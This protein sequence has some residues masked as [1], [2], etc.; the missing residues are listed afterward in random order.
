MLHRQGAGCYGHNSADD[1]AF[2][3]AF[4]A[5]RTPDRT[6]RVQWTREDEFSAA[7]MGSAM[8]V[9]LRAVLD[10][11]SRPADW[12]IDIWSPVH[13]QRPGMNGRANLLGA[14]ALPD[15]PPPAAE[16]NDV[17]DDAGGGATRNGQALYD[18]P[19][20][21][22]V[23]HLLPD[24]PVRTSS[25]R[26]LGAFANVFA[27]ESFMD[28]LAEIAGEDPVAY[29]LS[30]MSDP[31][32]RQVIETAA[33]MGDWFGTPARDGRARGFGFARYKNR[34][35]YAAVV[36][37]VEV[38][39]QVR[40]NRVWA[41]VDAGLVINPD[42]AAQPDRGRHHPGGELDPQGRCSLRRRA[43]RLRQ[44]GELPDLALHRGSGDR[45]PLHRRTRIS[46]RW[47]WAKRRSAPPRRRS[48]TRWRGRS[49]DAFA[50]CH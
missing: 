31:R 47:G 20:H 11:H 3:A 23:H 15:A 4:V 26:G 1:A 36:A 5:M 12:T 17:A 29:R 48:A 25:L 41:A 32:A 18:L 27:I 8:V 16:I 21:K 6:V 40:L 14:E 19:R 24:V 38:D 34:A 13:A 30:L 39:E 49:A 43:G 50:P 9:G 45:H 46:R 2:D 7:P 35:A 37:E 28:E 10:A 22:L 42:G 33:G 44:L